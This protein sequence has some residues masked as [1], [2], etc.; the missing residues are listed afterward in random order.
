[1][2]EL[3]RH[4]TEQPTAVQLAIFTCPHGV[5]DG[6]WQAPAAY[7]RSAS[8]TRRETFPARSYRR[9]REKVSVFRGFPIHMCAGADLMA[10]CMASFHPTLKL[11][12]ALLTI[13]LSGQLSTP[14]T[15]HFVP[16]VD[17]DGVH[18][19]TCWRKAHLADA[20]RGC[21]DYMGAARDGSLLRARRFPATKI[22]GKYQ[23]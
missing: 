1:V 17:D 20:A 10:Q 23:H 8:L 13:A 4:R 2:I 16:V 19:V 22:Q 7:G 15:T 21:P 11:G 9:A 5:G 14:Q 3:N 12:D 18:R 6:A